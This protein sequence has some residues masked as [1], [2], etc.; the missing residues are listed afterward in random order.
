[1]INVELIERELLWL[2]HHPER[3]DQGV[4]IVAPKK[5]SE[6]ST[7]RWHCGTTGCLAGWVVIH[8][9]WV[10]EP[11]DGY[12]IDSTYVTHPQ[13]GIGRREVEHVAT[14]LLGLEPDDA[15]VLFGGDLTLLEM[16]EYANEIT[17]GEISVP[18]DRFDPDG[19]PLP[20]PQYSVGE[21]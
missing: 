4:W 17:N 15:N 1:M 21:P 18:Y 12:E 9:G 8:D 14:E 16:F 11:S 13:R 7:E 6:P 5:L 20:A 10:P 3:H 19:D 2:L